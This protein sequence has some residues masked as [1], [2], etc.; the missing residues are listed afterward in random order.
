MRVVLHTGN[1]VRLQ[2]NALAL[3]RLPKGDETDFTD[4]EE[5]DAQHEQAESLPRERRR[6]PTRPVSAPEYIQERRVSQRQ[7]AAQPRI[8]FDR[9]DSA[10]LKRYRRFYQLPDVGPNS[11]KEQLVSAVGRHFME[12][13]VEEDSVIAS[14]IR[15]ARQQA[16]S[17]QG[18]Q[19]MYEE[20]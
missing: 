14:F 2:R 8:N 3:V 11:S 7:A 13:T 20:Y 10:A 19:P 6:R 18:V 9:L 5:T 4:D 1:E 12:Q 15:A 17:P 16:I